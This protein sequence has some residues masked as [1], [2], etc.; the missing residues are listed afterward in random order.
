MY[1][2]PLAGPIIQPRPIPTRTY[3]AVVILMVMSVSA[4]TT[5]HSFSTMRHLKNYLHSN[6]TT[7]C[8]RGLFSMH[9]YKDTELDVER[10]IHQFSRQKN[11]R[12]APLFRPDWRR[13]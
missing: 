13:R 1:R 6:M 12:L 11:R 2:D 7:E 8:M 4:V 5:E 9:V 10:I 3:T